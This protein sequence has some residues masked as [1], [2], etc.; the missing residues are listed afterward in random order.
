ME[1]QA[2]DAALMAGSGRRRQLHHHGDGDACRPRRQSGNVDFGAGVNLVLGDHLRKDVERGV[3][4]T[5]V[6]LISS[7]RFGRVSRWMNCM[8]EYPQTRVIRCQPCSLPRCGNG[9][10]HPAAPAP[11]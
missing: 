2:V 3:G 8:S 6:H 1:N 11:V 5:S 9:G 10:A 4:L 7:R